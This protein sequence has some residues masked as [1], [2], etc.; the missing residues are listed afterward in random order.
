MITKD[1]KLHNIEEQGDGY[2][3]RTVVTQVQFISEV[4]LLLQLKVRLLQCFTGSLTVL[5]SPRDLQKCFAVNFTR[6]KRTDCI[7]FSKYPYDNN[8]NFRFS[9]KFYQIYEHFDFFKFKN[10]HVDV[11]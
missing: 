7:A 11:I 9:K 10:L 3:R 1:E 4:F 2:G 5:G 8:T 6:Q